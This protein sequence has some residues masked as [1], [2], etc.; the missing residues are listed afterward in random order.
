MGEG[1]PV[2]CEKPY[3]R[4]CATK[5]CCSENTS[6]SP[7]GRS[8]VNTD[9]ME[10]EEGERWKGMK[11]QFFVEFSYV[12]L[13]LEVIEVRCVLLSFSLILSTIFLSLFDRSS[14]LKQ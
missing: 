13:A 8:E 7:F 12:C 9:L 6:V 4:G 11:S 10:K 14:F 3:S 1:R 5:P 2:L